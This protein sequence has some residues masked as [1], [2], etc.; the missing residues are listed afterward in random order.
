MLTYRLIGTTEAS[1]STPTNPTTIN[2]DHHQPQGERG[3]ESSPTMVD[4]EDDAALLTCDNFGGRYWDRTSDLF[5]VSERRR[6]RGSS[7]V[8]VCAG[9]TLPWCLRTV[10]VPGGT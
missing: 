1:G 9:Q 10:A 3:A 8:S 4:V 2:P 7:Y 6:V 5:R